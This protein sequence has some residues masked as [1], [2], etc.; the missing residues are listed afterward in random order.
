M[1]QV[2]YTHIHPHRE[3]KASVSRK[4][5]TEVKYINPKEDPPLE[6]CREPTSLN[7]IVQVH[8]DTKSSKCREKA[9]AKFFEKELEKENELKKLASLKERINLVPTWEA[10]EF[11]GEEIQ[12][13]EQIQNQD[14]ND[15]FQDIDLNELSAFEQAELELQRIKSA[16]K[17]KR[18]ADQQFQIRTERR[19]RHRKKVDNLISNSLSADIVSAQ[20]HIYLQ[21]LKTITR[22]NDRENREQKKGASSL[23][24]RSGSGDTNKTELSICGKKNNNKKMSGDKIVKKKKKK[25]RGKLLRVGNENPSIVELHGDVDLLNIDEESDE[26]SDKSV[27]SE[28][29][30]TV[31]PASPNFLEKYEQK[32][33]E[34]ENEK[35]VNKSG[36]SVGLK[37]V[38]K[39]Y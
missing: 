18:I 5:N 32:Y 7:P 29:T 19:I 31:P 33:E 34:M 24:L 3:N 8:K 28:K 13:T 10:R 30:Y 14:F 21:F 16:K 12:K 9:T 27:S 17:T 2:V 35:T 6:F 22:E 36:K 39:K 23:Y 38:K 25:A 20:E 1:N 11:V 4:V 15:R 37:K 26:D